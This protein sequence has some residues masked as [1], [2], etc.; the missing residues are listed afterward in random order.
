[1][2]FLF[3]I[4]ITIGLFIW[5]GRYITLK[6]CRAHV[7]LVVYHK[8]HDSIRAN[9]AAS[10]ITWHTCLEI[11]EAMNSYAILVGGQP[12]MRQLATSLGWRG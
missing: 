7:Y 12:Q 3:G 6:S 8:T 4:I 10:I 5:Y 11:N 1:M 9:L 2:G